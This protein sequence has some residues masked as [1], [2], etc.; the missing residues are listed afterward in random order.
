M[1]D[2]KRRRTGIIA[3]FLNCMELKYGSEVES[4]VGAPNTLL[5]GSSGTITE[6][7]QQLDLEDNMEEASARIS[8]QTTLYEF[9][10]ARLRFDKNQHH[11]VHVDH[12]EQVLIA[13]FNESLLLNCQAG[14][15]CDSHLSHH[16]DQNLFLQPRTT[17]SAQPPQLAQDRSTFLFSWV[18]TRG[19]G[20]AYAM[21]STGS[22]AVARFAPAGSSNLNDSWMED[23]EKR[24]LACKEADRQMRAQLPVNHFGPEKQRN[25]RSGEEAKYQE[26]C[27]FNGMETAVSARVYGI[28]IPQ[29]PQDSRFLYFTKDSVVIREAKGQSLLPQNHKHK[30]YFPYERLTGDFRILW[31]EVMFNGATSAN[32][33]QP[34]KQYGFM[35]A[36]M[37]PDPDAPSAASSEW[38]RRVHSTCAQATATTPPPNPIIPRGQELPKAGQKNLD[39]YRDP[40]KH[41]DALWLLN[42]WLNYGYPEGGAVFTAHYERWKSDNGNRKSMGCNLWHQLATYLKTRHLNHPYREDYLRM[43]GIHYTD[44]VEYLKK[45]PH[46]TD[47]RRVRT[48]IDICQGI[49]E[50]K[51]GPRSCPGSRY[52]GRLWHF[53]P[54][55]SGW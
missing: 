41:G 17:F 2:V 47:I 19:E 10:S 38:H 33:A 29:T 30:V 22:C 49:D 39:K 36:K 8:V 35:G 4:T 12:R 50:N 26:T 44:P 25:R 37:G 24:E 31:D 52:E 7:F 45:H 16:E 27:A 42:Q 5:E 40:P 18:N 53:G 14:G 13:L 9:S 20:V 55:T 6:V 11:Q 1:E 28:A 32:T 43:C 54:K 51:S 34:Q 21:S 46:T 23:Q 48:S 3:A 15:A